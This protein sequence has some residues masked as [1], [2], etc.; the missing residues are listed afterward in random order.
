MVHGK[1]TIIYSAK[2]QLFKDAKNF[3][4]QLI[5]YD[6]DNIPEEIIVVIDPYV[7]N[8][9]FTAAEGHPPVLLLYVVSQCTNTITLQELW[10]SNVKPSHLPEELKKPWF[11]KEAQRPLRRRA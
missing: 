10:S 7:V 1:L 2:Q 5:T 6:K 3:L 4:Q 11:V 8:P 9:A